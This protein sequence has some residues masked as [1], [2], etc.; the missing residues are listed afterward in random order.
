MARRAAERIGNRAETW[1]VGGAIDRDETKKAEALLSFSTSK[2]L[3]RSRRGIV[4][5][6]RLRCAWGTR[7]D[8]SLTRACLRIRAE[9]FGGAAARR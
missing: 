6:G 3:A 9:N 5:C 7:A 1:V 8:G 4:A 2:I